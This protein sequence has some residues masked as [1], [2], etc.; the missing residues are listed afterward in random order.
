MFNLLITGICVT[1]KS[2][3][4]GQMGPN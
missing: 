3:H 1:W 2:F 4:V